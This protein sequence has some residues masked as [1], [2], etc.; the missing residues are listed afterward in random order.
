V[1]ASETPPSVAELILSAISSTSVP[2]HL[3]RRPAV[4]LERIARGGGETRWYSVTNEDRLEALATR[5]SPG[6]SVSFYFDDRIE[7]RDL[8]DEADDAILDLIRVHGEAVVGV[9][10][11]DGLTIEIE[12]VSDVGELSEFLGARDSDVH[13][14]V[15]VFPERDDDDPGA[16]SIDLPDRDGVVRRHPH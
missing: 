14:F 9:L 4:V 6:S 11:P 10:S 16:I 15:G 1:S 8:N 5:L 7:Q 3:L 13:L 12:F 2:S